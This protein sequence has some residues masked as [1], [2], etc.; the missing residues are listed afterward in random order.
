VQRVEVGRDPAALVILGRQKL[1]E[2]QPPALVQLLDGPHEAEPNQRRQHGRQ[3]RRVNDR[4]GQGVRPL[5][6]ESREHGHD[7]E[8]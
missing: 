2:Q 8:F 1:V 4:G 3:H 6:D 7:P 5:R